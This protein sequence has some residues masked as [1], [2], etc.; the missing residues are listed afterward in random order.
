MFINLDL[1]T[2]YTLLRWSQKW[3]QKSQVLHRG[4]SGQEHTFFEIL[5]VI[6]FLCRRIAHRVGGTKFCLPTQGQANYEELFLLSIF[7]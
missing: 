3:K 6:L 2:D 5:V 1:K 7:C 4:D